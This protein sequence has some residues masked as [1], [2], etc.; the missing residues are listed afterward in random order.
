VRDA[1]VMSTPVDRIPIQV[2][3]S[4]LNGEL[5]LATPSIELSRS[6]AHQSLVMSSTF[7]REVRV[8]E[9]QSER[10]HWI[11]AQEAAASIG[12]S[13]TVAN[14]VFQPRPVCN[15]AFRC[16]S[17]WAQEVVRILDTPNPYDVA[18]ASTMRYLDAA[19]ARPGGI[20]G[21]RVDLS[22][23]ISAVATLQEQSDWSTAIQRQDL[24]LYRKLVDTWSSLSASGF[25]KV[26]SLITVGTDVGTANSP[27]VATASLDLEELLVFVDLER[28]AFATQVGEVRSVYFTVTNPSALPAFVQLD[29]LADDPVVLRGAEA[30]LPSTPW[31]DIRIR[32]VNAGS[33]RRTT[34]Q[35]LEGT[36]LEQRMQHKKSDLGATA[37]AGVPGASTQG[38]DASASFP[39]VFHLVDEGTGEVQECAR[40]NGTCL[41]VG[42]LGSSSADLSVPSTI[43]G[44]TLA[45][46]VATA[47]AAVVAAEDPSSIPPFFLSAAASRG[48]ALDPGETARLGPVLFR[49]P[50]SGV[51]NTSIFLRSNLTMFQEVKLSLKGGTGEPYLR[52]DDGV[53][54]APD[55]IPTLWFQLNTSHWRNAIASGSMNMTSTPSLTGTSDGRPLPAEPLI[56]PRPASN[57]IQLENHGN[58]PLHVSHIRIGDQHCATS[59]GF[60]VTGCESLP[61][62]IGPK[63]AWRI[64]I[65]YYTDCVSMN[66]LQSLSIVTNVGTFDAILHAVTDPADMVDCENARLEEL[67]SQPIAFVRLFAILAGLFGVLWSTR[68]LAMNVSGIWR[69]SKASTAAHT[70]DNPDQK[71]L[72][73]SGRRP[74]RSAIATNEAAASAPKGRRR[75]GGSQGPAA[76]SGGT[77]S[78]MNWKFL[79]VPQLEPSFETPL[80]KRLRARRAGKGSGSPKA[81]AVGGGQAQTAQE[82]RV[83]VKEPSLEKVSKP[84]RAQLEHN[85]ADQISGG[86]TKGEAAAPA[87][88][89]SQKPASSNAGT[90]K[91]VPP[92]GEMHP[93]AFVP[94][95]IQQYFQPVARQNSGGSVDARD[96]PKPVANAKPKELVDHATSRTNGRPSAAWGAGKES[97]VTSKQQQPEHGATASLDAT[98]TKAPTTRQVRQTVAKAPF[99]TAVQQPKL[100]TP[101]QS[102]QV[103]SSQAKP[104]RDPAASLPATSRAPAGPSARTQKGS[105][106]VGAAVSRQVTR[107]NST[108]PS[109]SPPVPLALQNAESWPAPQGGHRVKPAGPTGGDPVSSGNVWPS[110]TWEG[111]FPPYMPAPAP[112]PSAPLRDLAPFEPLG[113]S[114]VGTSEDQQAPGVAS[115][116]RDFATGTS[117]TTGSNGDAFN[118]SPLFSSGTPLFQP[119]GFEL[120]APATTIGGND[121]DVD[122]L[123]AGPNLH[124]PEGIPGNAED[125]V[126]NSFMPLETMAAPGS[127]P[128]STSL[129]NSRLVN[130]MQPD[131]IGTAPAP[132]PTGAPGDPPGVAGSAATAPSYH[133][134][135]NRGFF[136]MGGFFDADNDSDGG[137]E[138]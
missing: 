128:R 73:K 107:S 89:H 61:V 67:D 138:E 99:A 1:A 85:G 106:S 102:S 96:K 23:V 51:W 37:S 115:N 124:Q 26:H 68:E 72:S 3:Y 100:S 129:S 123:F 86:R 29:S 136:G 108:S 25:N 19:S 55:S 41:E 93:E 84:Q 16:M 71:D 22:T 79:N 130:Y 4:V 63:Q 35:A 10:G 64:G 76:N 31:W 33:G 34:D 2:A 21:T 125:P 101:R 56:W 6:H 57:M 110:S 111:G 122:L 120:F 116:G 117:S 127:I 132:R 8:S 92:K 119:P 69:S 134:E 137:L 87:R 46:A 80:V 133:D 78:T 103:P 121:A 109:T 32:T 40:E 27:I 36:V 58:L 66:E 126:F 113:S 14:I 94:G 135:A 62:V 45:S 97:A 59:S 43:D 13:S 38:G 83:G 15:N 98:H 9:V 75:R 42:L 114:P 90:S 49:P 81:A 12:A 50:T 118:P 60:V 54:H 104:G 112:I 105:D 39:A 74:G 18:S 44:L 82:L 30:S 52:T 5:A 53:L 11:Q 47:A 28:Q 7:A 77:G 88:N 91:S 17:R 20:D 65:H 131:P 48:L 24:E 95:S 70:L